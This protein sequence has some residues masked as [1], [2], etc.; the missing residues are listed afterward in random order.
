MNI[1]SRQPATNKNLI[2]TRARVGE[3]I[4][5]NNKNKKVKKEL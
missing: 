2:K 4:Y 5:S 1:I 3:K